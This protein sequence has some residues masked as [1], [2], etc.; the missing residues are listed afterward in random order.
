MLQR[1]YPS[2]PRESSLRRRSA[3][4]RSSTHI[5][6]KSLRLTGG[7]TGFLLIHGLGGTPIEM[8][9]IAQGLARAGYTVHVPQ[10]AGHCGSVDDLTNTGWIDWYQTVEDEHR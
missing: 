8:R 9:Y 5:A 10:L 6:D 3:V 4:T 1:L 2:R 7:H